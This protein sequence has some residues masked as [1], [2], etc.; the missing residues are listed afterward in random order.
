MPETGKI[1][2]SLPRSE[3]RKLGNRPNDT[4]FRSKDRSANTR[5]CMV[6]RARGLGGYTSAKGKQLVMRTADLGKPAP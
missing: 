4:A 1:L 6:G 3:K 5:Y 2:S